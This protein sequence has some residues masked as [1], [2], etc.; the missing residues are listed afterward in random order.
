MSANLVV[1]HED[2]L[3]LINFYSTAWKTGRWPAITKDK[4]WIMARPHA[5]YGASGGYG[6]PAGRDFV[7]STLPS[8]QPVLI[9]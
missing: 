2:I 5:K 4:V 9:D 8:Y 3:S 7:C 6:V 1:P